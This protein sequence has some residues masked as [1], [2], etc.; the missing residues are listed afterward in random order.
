[1]ATRSG[2]TVLL[3]LFSGDRLNS[4]SVGVLMLAL[5]WHLGMNLSPRL[6]TIWSS[7]PVSCCL[8]TLYVF[9]SCVNIFL[10]IKWNAGLRPGPDTSWGPWHLRPRDYCFFLLRCYSQ[11]TSDNPGDSRFLNRK[12][13]SLCLLLKTQVCFEHGRLSLWQYCFL[14]SH[15]TH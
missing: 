2:V 8:G 6:V 12:S 5:A 13:V 7:P 3:N 11:E 15:Q 4:E 10:R 9:I 14:H 1:M